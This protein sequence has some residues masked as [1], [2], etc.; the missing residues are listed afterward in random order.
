MLTADSG[1]CRTTPRTAAAILA[2]DVEIPNALQ[3]IPLCHFQSGGKEVGRLFPVGS[4]APGSV[5]AL[6]FRHGYPPPQDLAMSSA[7]PCA[8]RHLRTLMYHRQGPVVIAGRAK[9]ADAG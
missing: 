6:I 4:A 7:V 2:A 3:D 5:F 9:A 1:A 8:V